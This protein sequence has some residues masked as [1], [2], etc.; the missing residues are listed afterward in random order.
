MA[1][2]KIYWLI[3]QLYRLG[4]TEMVTLN[5]INIL[6]EDYDITIVTNQDYQGG[7]IYKLPEG[8]KIVSLGV[9][10]KFLRVDDYGRKYFFQLR[11]IEWVFYMLFVI[12]YAFFGRRKIRKKVLQMTTPDDIILASSIDNYIMVPKERTFFL[13]FHFNAELLHSLTNWRLAYHLMNKPSKMIFITKGTL[14][15]ARKMHRYS[16]IDMTMCYNPVRLAPHENYSYHHNTLIFIGRLIDQKRPLA[17]IHIAHLLKKDG[18]VFTLN[19]IGEGP[20]EEKMKAEIKLLNL[21][22]EV[23]LKGPVSDPTEELNNSDLMVFPS[24]FEGFGLVT[25][26]ANSQS[27]PVI[28]SNWGAG[29][30]EAVQDGV[31]G[32]IIESGKNED[33]AKAIISLL[34]DQ[35]KL[36]AMKKSSY[37]FAQRL[38]DQAIRETWHKILG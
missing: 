18:L 26:E 13:H 38:S 37:K 32:Y 30:Y 25:S 9:P 22:K 34:S 10:E 16:K 6:K 28:S 11:W 33:F 20:L 23:I 27:V 7:S 19:I 29:V 12:N 14:E 31:S 17:L 15:E 36:T 21:E 3:Q 4:G 2:K 8:V 1:K 5:I 35:E 24:A